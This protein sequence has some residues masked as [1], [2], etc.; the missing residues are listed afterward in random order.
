MIL[1][2]AS[3]LMVAGSSSFI[4]QNM[5]GLTPLQNS[6]LM[7]ACTTGLVIAGV[8]YSRVGTRFSPT[9]EL[10]AVQVVMLLNCTVFLLFVV[11][12]ALTVPVFLCY[13]LVFTG[14]AA[15]VLSNGIGLAIA[16]V[17]GGIGAATA[18][19]GSLQY[20]IG[21]LVMPFGGIMGES[22]ALPVAIG[23]TALVALSILVR[24]GIDRATASRT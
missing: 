19:M 6:V 5:L 9:R 1:T 13:F 11:F 8:V 15:I 3:L 14:S 18:L 21:A 20:G 7:S 4:T 12:D 10:W 24:F 17:A 23:T 2:H 22:S 16:Q